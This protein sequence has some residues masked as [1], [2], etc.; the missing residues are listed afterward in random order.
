MTSLLRLIAAAE[1]RHLRPALVPGLLHDRRDIRIGDEALPAV[2]IPV[3][4]HPHPVS[5][6]GVA[7]HERA[8]RAVQLALL[9][10]LGGEDTREA[11]EVL[12]RRRCQ[13]H[14]GPPY[15]SGVSERR[16]A[17]R[18]YLPEGARPT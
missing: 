10:T 1:L 11:V 18:E 13:E 5:L 17:W 14:P 2:E 8:L 16:R 4:D 15:A 6:A 9:S 7:E 12:D 3:E